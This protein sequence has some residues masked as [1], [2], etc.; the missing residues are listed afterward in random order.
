[1]SADT[2]AY[3]GRAAPATAGTVRY[4]RPR[5]AFPELVARRTA[6]TAAIWGAATV[7]YVYATVVGF[8]S[9][10]ATAALRR[11]VLDALAGNVGLRALIGD[12]HGIDAV[13]GFTDWRV[14][15]VISMATGVWAM[16]A[17]V[18]WLRGEED[19]GRWEVTL[20]GPTTAG[21]A[22]LRVLAALGTGLVVMWVLVTAGTALVGAGDLGV[23]PGHAAVFALVIIATPAMFLAV[24][25]LASQLMA[26]RA[27]AGAVSAAV[28]GVAFTLR[29]L[30]D[31]A[32]AAHWL[33][34]VSPLGWIEQ[35]RPLGG[36]RPVWLLPTVA[37]TAGLG[38]LAV[39]LAAR[40]DVGT[41]VLA[42][43][44]SAP[45]RTRMLSDPTL[46]ALRMSRGSIAAW[47]AATV[48]AGLLYG[49]F[50]RSAA[51]A[52]AHSSVAQKFAGALAPGAAH[53]GAQTYAGI[54]FLVITTLLMAYAAAA[55][56][57]VRETEA[58]GYLDNLLVRRV[59]RLAWL[60]GRV[61]IAGAVV[62]AGG[63]L[64]GTA[65]WAGAASQHAGLSGSELVLAGVNA[66]APALL[67][68]G[69]AVFTFGFAPRATAV[70]GY[71]LLAWA[72]LVEM[73]GTAVHL[74][75]WLMDTSL[76]H[77]LALAPIV[78]PNWRVVGTYVALGAAL[79]SAG[80]WRFHRRDMAAG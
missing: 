79:V 20:A 70:A 55:A 12:T 7:L 26:T 29:A 44:D 30:G 28:F 6:R 78:D 61:G 49:T 77:H 48:A 71:A 75:H 47:L 68:L 3:A 65:F 32:P 33:V 13:A 50:A 66:T 21:A 39:A 25:A 59:S 15:G 4:R 38:A 35:V 22:T 74:N 52:F 23:P 51:D 31:A 40:R 8:R 69:A 18:R 72:F 41:S 58:E 17:A 16:M 56:A 37:F 80:A 53:L 19:S 36:P 42:D 60:A 73:V 11:P 46:F 14:I 76:L 10:G 67:V 45:P 1:M 2:T 57:S 64:A 43:R 62:V 27:R 5:L 9:L 34:Y 24:G 54:V 63:L